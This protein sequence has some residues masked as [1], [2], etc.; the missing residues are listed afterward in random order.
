MAEVAVETRIHDDTVVVALAGEIDISTSQLVTDAIDE[1][2]EGRT[3]PDVLCCDLTNVT[4]LDSTGISALLAGRRAS[5]DAGTEMVLVG[6]HG[7]V[8]RVLQLSRVDSL[9]RQF[10][11]VEEFR[12]SHVSGSQ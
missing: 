4:F 2:L 10:G 12:S 1:A 6:S 9:F 11:N 3:R 8:R 5:E 7:N